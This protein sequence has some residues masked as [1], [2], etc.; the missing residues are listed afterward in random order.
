MTAR[1]EPPSSVP[2]GRLPPVRGRLTANAAIGRQTWFGVGG[3]AEVLFQPADA[4]DLAVFLA[5][6]PTEIPVTVIGAGSN[7]L[8][9]GWWRW[10]YQVTALRNLEHRGI[11]D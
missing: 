11:N 7:L 9:R 2:M 1:W 4:E 3:A 6:L 5:G 10:E 8:V